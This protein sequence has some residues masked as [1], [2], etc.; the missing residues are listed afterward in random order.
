MFL[1]L[2]PNTF[3]IPHSLTLDEKRDML[4]VADRENGRIQCFDSD[5]KFHKEITSPKFGGLVFAV[6]FN[7][8]SKSVQMFLY[9]QE[10]YCKPYIYNLYQNASV[11]CLKGQ[12][13]VAE[14]LKS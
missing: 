7:E 11:D 13:K 8:P 9:T 3:S 2:L 10:L 1:G 12:D 14:N 4:Y 5:G 6:D